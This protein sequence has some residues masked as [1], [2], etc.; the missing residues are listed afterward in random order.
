MA[1]R[2][3][4]KDK[5]KKYADAMRARKQVKGSSRD[6]PIT[7]GMPTRELKSRLVS[8][9]AVYR[10]NLKSS[11]KLMSDYESGKSRGA[12]ASYK[13]MKQANKTGKLGKNVIKMR[14]ELHSRTKK[15]GYN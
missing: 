13:V 11:E 1:K 2:V 5:R 7:F 4:K 6:N 12:K 8:Q 15:K 14:T 3:T 10:K 9:T